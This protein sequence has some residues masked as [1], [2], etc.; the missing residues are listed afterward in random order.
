MTSVS[1]RGAEPAL[2][3]V[4]AGH[5]PAM[6]AVLAMPAH[7]PQPAALGCLRSAAKR[8]HQKRKP[9]RAWKNKAL[10]ALRFDRGMGCWLRP[11]P[12]GSSWSGFRAKL[13]VLLKDPADVALLPNDDADPLGHGRDEFAAMIKAD[14]GL[15]GEAVKLAGIKSQ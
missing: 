12:Q 10:R 13:P 3:D 8:A 9:C 14:I 1:Y 4:V 6:F 11:G 5:L 15:W 2:T 7:K